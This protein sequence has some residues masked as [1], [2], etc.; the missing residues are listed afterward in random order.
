MRVVKRVKLIKYIVAHN[1]FFL[2]LP[3]QGL[4]HQ[5]KKIIFKSDLGLEI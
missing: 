5:N 1:M 3:N 2:R 4:V